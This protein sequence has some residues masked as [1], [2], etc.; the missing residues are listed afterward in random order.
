MTQDQK[1]RRLQEARDLLNEAVEIVSEIFQGDGNVQ[2]Y[3]IEQVA[4]HIEKSNQYNL[5]INDLIEKIEN[6]EEDEN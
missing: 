5:D 2:A 6:P 1:I 4:E 3:W